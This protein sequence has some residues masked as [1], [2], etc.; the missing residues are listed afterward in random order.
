MWES[1]LVAKL[2][3]LTADKTAALKDEM[4]VV[5]SAYWS[6]RRK[7]AATACYWVGLMAAARGIRTAEK[8]AA[9]LEVPEAEERDKTW[10]AMTVGSRGMMTAEMSAALLDL[11]RVAAMACL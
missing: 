7:V 2:V 4:K 5:Q 6:A 9:T 10:A 1:E 3:D 11:R 8:T